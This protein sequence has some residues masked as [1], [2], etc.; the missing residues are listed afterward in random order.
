MPE[1]LAA[2]QAVAQQ[3][4]IALETADL[5]AF[6]GLLDP[7]VH[8]GAP[9]DASPSCQNRN[10]VLA[11]YQRGWEAGVRARISEVVV[12]GDQ[13]ILVGLVVVGNRAAKDGEEQRWQVLTVHGGRVVDIVGYDERGEAVARARSAGLSPPR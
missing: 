8:W 9:E 7:D 12:I 1:Q 4:K 6:S 13:L 11:W 2:T 10:Q 5:S 3:V